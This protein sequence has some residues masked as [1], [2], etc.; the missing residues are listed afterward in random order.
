[1]SE[2]SDWARNVIHSVDH[3]VPKQTFL[4][5]SWFTSS[6]PATEM[7]PQGHHS[8]G[9]LKTGHSQFQKKFITDAME[10]WPSGSHLLLQTVTPQEIELRALGCKQNSK[11][12]MLFLSIKAAGH[13]EPG[14]PC[15]ARWK[16]KNRRQWVK[17]FALS[18]SLFKTLCRLQCS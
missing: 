9:V 11:K 1:M 2:G 13:T 16:D 6:Q 8:V 12:V 14:K 4:G 3:P 18:R 10:S 7:A 17:A 15:M 5:D